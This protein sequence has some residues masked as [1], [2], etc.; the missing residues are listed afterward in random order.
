[1]NTIAYVFIF[2]GIIIFQ[3]VSK[4]RALNITED[5][6]D[7][8]QAIVNGNADDFAEIFNRTGDT[9][10]PSAGVIVG[11][12]VAEA[13]GSA[14]AGALTEQQKTANQRISYWAIRLGEAAKGYRWAATG[15]DYYDCSGLMYRAAQKVG[16]RGPRFFT[17]TVQ[18]MPGFKRIGS[19]SLGVSQASPGDIVL[20]PGHHMGVVIGSNRMYSARNPRAGIGETPIKGFR[21]EDPIFLRFTPPGS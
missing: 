11:S 3:R 15:P 2:I 4:G 17:A 9:A 8:F 6:S 1:M 10:T 5:L 12:A 19:P 14:A 13:V 18:G 20:W 16:Y 21:K 7:A